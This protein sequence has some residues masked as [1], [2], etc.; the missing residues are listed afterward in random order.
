MFEFF[1]FSRKTTLE[2][3]G[4]VFANLTSAWFAIILIA[5][6]LTGS[7]SMQDYGFLLIKNLPSAIVGFILTA[8]IAEK[9]K[10]L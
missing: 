5:P 8:A 10:Q 6:G 4:T 9:G 2:T 3:F 7:T 1:K